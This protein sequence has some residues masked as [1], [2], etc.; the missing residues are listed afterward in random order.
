MFGVNVSPLQGKFKTANSRVITYNISPIPPLTP[1]LGLRGLV[2]D[3]EERMRR[4]EC[5]CKC[6]MEI[7][8]GME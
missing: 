8:R 4:K 3:L 7:F 1:D 5:Y 2:G 6:G